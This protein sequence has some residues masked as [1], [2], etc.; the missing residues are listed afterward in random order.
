MKHLTKK[1]LNNLSIQQLDEIRLELGH[2]LGYLTREIQIHG[3]KADYTRKRT[4]EKY[5]IL[6]KAVLQHKINTG[7]K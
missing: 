7:P 6:V 2:S 1:Q 3:F 4:I 5:L